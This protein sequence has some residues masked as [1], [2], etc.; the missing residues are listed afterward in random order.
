MNTGVVVQWIFIK[1]VQ[2]PKSLYL[3]C[4]FFLQQLT[5]PS[6]EVVGKEYRR[7]AN[8]LAWLMIVLILLAIMGQAASAL[9]SGLSFEELFQDSLVRLITLTII[10]FI[11]VYILSRSQYYTIGSILII[12]TLFLAT[13]FATV[14]SPSDIATLLPFL[15]LSAFLGSLLLSARYTFAV[16][17]ISGLGGLLV[18]LFTTELSIIDVIDFVV[19]NTILSLLISLSSYIRW[20]NLIQIEQQSEK[21]TEALAMLSEAKENMEVELNKRLDEE[22]SKRELAEGKLREA[23]RNKMKTL[24]EALEQEKRLVQLKDRFMTTMSHEFRTPLTVIGSS[25]QLLERHWNNMSDEKRNERL[26]RIKS[27]IFHLR[28]M[29]DDLSFTIKAQADELEANFETVN[30]DEFC[31]G[32]INYMEISMSQTPF[33]YNNKGVIDDILADKKL[34]NYIITN[35]LTNAS[36][37]SPEKTP[38]EFEIAQEEQNISIRVSDQGIGIPP[39]DKNSLFTPYF[40]AGN[41]EDYQGIGIGL[42]IVKD[43]VDL[44][45]GNIS[46][47]STLGKGTTFTVVL[48]TKQVVMQM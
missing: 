35:L 3:K 37:Y 39:E 28:T 29:L 22:L 6:S 42:S 18:P 2:R 46:V 38:I 7:R 4:F 10:I 1:E 34:L 19:Y 9:T 40:R 41:V 14:I 24:E 11:F 26:F 5:E 21:L 44:H 36:K 32:I 45:Y 8:L 31:K 20:Q 48:P 27:Q 30:L 13:I 33:I 16:S 47:E 43:C 15:V 23:E 17:I 25:T 12:A